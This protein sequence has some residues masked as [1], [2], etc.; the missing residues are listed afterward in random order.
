MT[1]MTL[2]IQEINSGAVFQVEGRMMYENDSQV[3]RQKLD[4]E[5]K[6]GKH[7]VVADLSRVIG[8]SS[9]GLGILISAHRLTHERGASF[10]LASLSEK[11]RSVLQITRLNSIFEIFDNVEEAVAKA[12]KG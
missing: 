6:L 12:K 8:M 4:E 9:T 11:V 7:W 5:L 3:F 1:G 2:L 10:K